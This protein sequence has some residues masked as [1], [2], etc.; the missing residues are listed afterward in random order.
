M[1]TTG[2]SRW[3]RSKEERGVEGRGF[4]R[5]RKSEGEGGGESKGGREGGIGRGRKK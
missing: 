2:G 1:P 3:P 4:S 5:D